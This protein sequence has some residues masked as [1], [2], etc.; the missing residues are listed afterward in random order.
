VF[1]TV[2]RIIGRQSAI[3]VER[4]AYTTL[5]AN[6]DNFFSA[7]N[8]NLLTGATSTLNVDSLTD[9]EQLFTDQTDENGDPIMVM[10]SV[11]LVPT[12]LKTTAATLLNSTELARATVDGDNSPIDRLPT[13]NPWSGNLSPVVSPW[14]SSQN[15]PGSSGLAW[16]LVADPGQGIAAVD[17]AFLNGRQAPTIESADTDFNVLGVQMRGYHDFGVAQEDHRAI[18]K[19]TG[20]V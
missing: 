20:E 4:A 9:A 13:G 16:Y 8:G 2:P 7:G 11:L 17:V 3:A 18:V 12:T 10:P 5:L 15:L 19:V 6:D 14:L 1:Q